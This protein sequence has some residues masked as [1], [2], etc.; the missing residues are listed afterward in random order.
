VVLVAEDGAEGG[1]RGAGIDG[2]GV[3]IS[4]FG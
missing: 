1:F 2:L 4:L 3:G